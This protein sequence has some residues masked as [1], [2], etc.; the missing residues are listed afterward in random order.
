MLR[1][2][3]LALFT[4]LLSMAGFSTQA[5]TAAF[6]ISPRS[7]CPP[8]S[9]NFTDQSTGSG[10]SYQWSLGNGVNPTNASP[11]TIYSTPGRYPIVLT[12]TNASGTSTFTDT[13]NVYA[14]PVVSFTG[15]NLNGCSPLST[16]FS[17]AVTLSGP[18]PAAYSWVFGDGAG[19]TTANPLHIYQTGGTFNVTVTVSNGVNC[20]T[21]AL[22]NGYVTALTPPV[23]SFTTDK[24]Y[25]CDVPANVRFT[26]AA[27]G[28]G[29][30]TYDWDFGD[31]SPHGTLASQPHTYTA[32]GSYNVR[33]I[34][35]DSRGCKDTVTTPGAVFVMALKPSFTAPAVCAGNITTFSN[36]TG[37]GSVAAWDYGDG[38]RDTGD[39]LY[40]TYNTAASY[41]VIMTVTI[42]NCPK[43]DTQTVR[44]HPYSRATVTQSPLASCP[45]P[46]TLA[47][48]ANSTVSG[49]TYTWIWPKAPHLD[50][51]P[52][53][54]RTYTR[55]IQDTV[56]LAAVTPDGCMDTFRYEPI[57][58]RPITQLITRV[59]VAD[60]F[61]G[62]GGGCAPYTFTIGKIILTT[63][64]P[65]SDVL[66]YYPATITS[67]NWDFADGTTSTMAHPT[68]TYSAPGTYRIR[69]IITTSN[70]CKDTT[71][72]PVSV[73]TP[74]KPSYVPLADSIC[75]NMPVTFINTTRNP[76]PGVR[77]T[78]VIDRE[79]DKPDTSRIT[80]QTFDE[81]R[82]HPFLVSLNRGCTDTFSYPTGVK[83]L[84]PISKFR[85]ST[86]C[87]PSTTVTFNNFTVD[88][89]SQ[90]WMF[91]DGSFDTSRSPTHTYPASA[92]YQPRLVSYNS[93]TGCIDTGNK[94]V[95]TAAI[96]LEA[97]DYDFETALTNICVGNRIGFNADYPAGNLG[98]HSSTGYAWFFGSTYI[99]F[100]GQPSTIWTFDT[101][102][103]HDVSLIIRYGK[104]GCLDT[105]SKPQYVLA[106]K[107]V[108]NFGADITQGCLPLYVIVRDSTSTLPG[109]DPVS[110]QWKFGDRDSVTNSHDTITH[111]YTAPGAYDFKVVVMDANGC[112]DSLLKLNYIHV[113]KTT[114][115]VLDAGPD[116]TCSGAEVAFQ[117]AST[118]YGALTQVWDFGDGTTDTARN[119]RHRYLNKGN[120]TVRLIVSD[121]IGCTDTFTRPRPIAVT[122]PVAG[123]SSSPKVS[124]CTQQLVQFSNTTTEA[125]EYDWDYGAGSQGP[126]VVQNPLHTY[127][128]SGVYTVR[129]IAS[130]PVGCR[131]TAYDTVRIL[132]Y[133][134]AFDYTPSLGCAPVQVAFSPAVTNVPKLTWDFGDGFTDTSS[135]AGIVRHTYTQPGAY[136]PRVIFSD[137]VSCNALSSGLDSIY[138]DKVKAD[139]D[140]SV[141]CA[142]TPF[143]LNSLSTARYGLPGTFSWSSPAATGSSTGNPGRL[144]IPGPG[145]HPVTLI[146]TNAAGCADTVTKT[147]FIN[148]LPPVSAGRD[149]AV[150]PG[151]TA[152]LFASGALSFVWAPSNLNPAA[153]LSCTSC[154]TPLASTRVPV[155]FTVS[156]VDANGCWGRDS[157]NVTIQLK[158]TSTTGPAG[159]IC[160]G[161]SYRLSAEGADRY[162]WYPAATL[163]NPFIPDPTATPTTTTT[164][165]VI[166]QEGNC[167][168]DT[169]R[170]QVV[171]NARPDF[172]AGPDKII[173]LGSATTLEPRGNFSRIAWLYNDT[174]LTC[175]N[176][177]NPNAHPSYTR[178][179]WARATNEAGCETLDSVTVTVR[180]NGSQVFI[181]NTFTPNG[182]GQ[183]DWFFPQG[184]GLDRMTTFRVFNRWGE[185][186]FETQH[187][188]LN[189]PSSGWDGTFKGQ[190]LAPD[191]YIYTMSSRC[192]SGEIVDFKGDITLIR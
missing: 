24:T 58:I 142:D 117:S 175:W 147:V 10:L 88:A 67:W 34:V 71:Y 181:P 137:G 26:A 83:I 101:A 36:T 62:L 130:D 136:L 140:W 108:V 30:F 7:G 123:F 70:G 31:N 66:Q 96:N 179:Y 139:F 166:S 171:V 118:G 3:T 176:C 74:V 154:P 149:T 28:V 91:G 52:N 60:S 120:F 100:T 78:W 82:I 135:N 80:V 76:P 6:S 133:N 17:S 103:Y 112:R 178:T 150:C 146:A 165:T 186:V 25:H 45:A 192:R 183:N 95:L 86:A 189:S 99:D 122:R 56:Y 44:S 97:P 125:T 121:S 19:D 128:N 157:V 4:I 109:Y 170:T 11:S 93:K 32:G 35:T 115:I 18:N 158:T 153:V 131:D 127:Q 167:Q 90:L 53:T 81:V 164:Y 23:A 141:P 65:V 47:F 173:A 15:T 114:A 59:S 77:F 145:S 49:T 54:T 119:P 51:G 8:L 50:T 168:V 55:N 116:G 41:R 104:N 110:W 159:S 69:S 94:G 106:S 22:R 13:L 85:D 156:G 134:G 79:Y 39:V 161:E 9:V 144:R 151:D 155:V 38:S 188:P 92:V 182:D 124:P 89:T 42:A 113:H 61:S 180:C 12:V 107:P 46:V 187:I 16:Q 40:H 20:V 152:H 14:P 72:H 111:L 132:G 102:G 68:H 1:R 84:P 64:L 185:L 138:V 129:L 29:P 105:L 2:N 63:S 57:V 37:T 5:Q 75:F 160:Y 98:S 143:T 126:I 148:T 33:L 172:S 177:K 27:S 191:T 184:E 174:T 169:Q 162:E 21:T 87:F 190:P 163:D 73:D 48:Q 43:S